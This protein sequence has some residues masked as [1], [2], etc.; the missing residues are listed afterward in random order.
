MAVGENITTGK[1]WRWGAFD[2]GVDKF[3]DSEIT[4]SIQRNHWKAGDQKNTSS[5]IN[6]SQNVKIPPYVMTG[7][8]AI[9]E[10][11]LTYGKDALGPGKKK[12]GQ[13]GE[14]KPEIQEEIEQSICPKEGYPLPKIDWKVESLYGFPFKCFLDTY[15][16]YHHIKMAK[17]DE[18]KTAIIHD[19]GIFC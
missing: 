7:V 1:D 6:N 10:H 2:L 12:R 9:A 8:P 15:K 17:E 4:I 3:C 14:Q 5:S 11:R 19:Q 18:E 16:G 13:A